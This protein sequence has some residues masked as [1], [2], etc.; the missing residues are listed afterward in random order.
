MYNEALNY[1]LNRN[2]D[3]NDNC[4]VLLRGMMELTFLNN[5]NKL[6]KIFNDIFEVGIGCMSCAS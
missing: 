5:E 2:V 3:V 4:K 1:L 6:I